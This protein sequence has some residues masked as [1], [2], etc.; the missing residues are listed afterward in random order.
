QAGRSAPVGPWQRFLSLLGFHRSVLV[1]AFFCALLMTVLGI[2][3]SYFIQHLVDNVLV[4]NERRFL[5]A[6]GIRMVFVIL[7]CALFG[8]LRQYLLAH[9]GRKVD[10]TLIAGY[11]RH[12][13]GL[14]MQFFEMRRVGEILSRV[15]DAAKVREAISGTS[16]TAVVDGTLVVILL[17]VLWVY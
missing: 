11:A 3:T 9:A 7:F 12:L 14:P 13:L 2:A 5:N 1:E 6:L 17:V 8:V 4:R 15:N 16:L 10:L